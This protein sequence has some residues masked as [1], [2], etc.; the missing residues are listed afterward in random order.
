MQCQLLVGALRRRPEFHVT[1]CALDPDVIL[2]ATSS[3][4]VQVAILNADS[5]RDDWP[6]MTVV[7]RLHL[8]HPE[9]A[10]IILLDTYDRDIVVNAFRSGA[11]GLFCFSQYPFRLLCKCIQSV[12]Q[13]Q[14]WANSEQMQYL[15]ES[16][17]QVPSLH[18]VNSRG[19]RLLTPR[20]EQVVALVADGLSNR[21]V[22]R[23]LCLSEHTIKKYLFRI[24]RQAGHFEPRGTGPVRAESR[25]FPASRMGSRSKSL[26]GTTYLGHAC[27]TVSTTRSNSRRLAPPAACTA[28]PFTT[29]TT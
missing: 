19:M 22:A 17:S 2:H 8:A 21:E 29:V 10:K 7:R 15:V 27:S 4:P 23:E 18:M 26:A 11:R 24:F 28:I 1:S 6:D 3:L 5:P 12:H 16:L 9:V 20:E 13:G 25:R 14:V